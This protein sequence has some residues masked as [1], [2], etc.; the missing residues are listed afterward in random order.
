MDPV[1]DT[2]AIASADIYVTS[3]KPSLLVQARIS[4][5]A[6]RKECHGCSSQGLDGGMLGSCLSDRGRVVGETKDVRLTNTC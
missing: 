1:T 3:A 2:L 6:E 4:S 5:A